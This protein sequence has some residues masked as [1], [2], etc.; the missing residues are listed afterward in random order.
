MRKTVILAALLLLLALALFALPSTVYCPV[1]NMMCYFTGKIQ[2]ISGV[3]FY[4]YK[5]P[6]A[7]T[8]LVRW[9]A[10]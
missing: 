1:D 8:F 2:T 4:Q 7:H 3:M 9:D 10:K 5:C 6:Q